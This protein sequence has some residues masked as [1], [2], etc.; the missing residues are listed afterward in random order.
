MFPFKLSLNRILKRI[1]RA[2]EYEI[3]EIMKALILWQNRAYPEEEL[4]IMSLAKYDL[5]ARTKQIDLYA[6]A[7]KKYIHKRNMT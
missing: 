6:A 3:N 7:L 4:V 1:D 5:E 2:D